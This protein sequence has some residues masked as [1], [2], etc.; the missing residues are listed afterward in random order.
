MDFLNPPLEPEF[1]EAEGAYFRRSAVPRGLLTEVWDARRECWTPYTGDQASLYAFRATP[2]SKDQL[3]EAAGPKPTAPVKPKDHRERP[4]MIDLTE[5][6]KGKAFQILAAPGKEM[7][8]QKSIKPS[9]H[10]LPIVSGKPYDEA[11][12]EEDLALATLDRLLKKQNEK[13]PAP[14]KPKKGAK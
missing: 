11:V 13:A 2:I 5:Q 9:T 7:T 4:R 6:N 8:G 3:P 10:G 1:Y 12:V 14:R